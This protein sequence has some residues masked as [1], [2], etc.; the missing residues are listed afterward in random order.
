MGCEDPP[1]PSL[2]ETFLPEII[3][4]NK[5]DVAIRLLISK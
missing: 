1:Q 2:F 5:R 4:A 3:Q